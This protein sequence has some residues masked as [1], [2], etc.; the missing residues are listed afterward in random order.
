MSRNVL[1]RCIRHICGELQGHIWTHNTPHVYVVTFATSCA[2]QFLRI[3][4]F[5]QFAPRKQRDIDI[6][7]DVWTLLHAVCGTFLFYDDELLDMNILAHQSVSGLCLYTRLSCYIGATAKVWQFF[8][9]SQ[10]EEWR[11]DLL[12]LRFR[13]IFGGRFSN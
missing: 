12:T 2:R 1:L 3:V 4:Y 6:V 8:D 9:S 5:I 11:Y 7:V 10:S 13:C